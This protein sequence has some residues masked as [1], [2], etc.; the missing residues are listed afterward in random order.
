MKVYSD[1]ALKSPEFLIP[2]I[3]PQK[4]RHSEQIKNCT[5][6]LI[7]RLNLAIHPRMTG[8]RGMFVP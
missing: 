8:E 5:A 3:C 6:N 4:G 1:A 2:A 7:D